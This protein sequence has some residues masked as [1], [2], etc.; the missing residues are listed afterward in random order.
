MSEK[1]LGVASA[2]YFPPER[3]RAQSCNFSEELL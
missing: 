3:K 1:E 2:G